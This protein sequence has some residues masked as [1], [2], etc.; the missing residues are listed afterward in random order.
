MVVQRKLIH[1]CQFCHVFD[2]NHIVRED[3]PKASRLLSQT[4]CIK[5]KAR[6]QKLRHDINA[7]CMTVPS[8]GRVRIADP[9]TESWRIKFSLKGDRFLEITPHGDR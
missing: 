3:R 1:V 2:Q 8:F 4:S 6:T 7:V 9:N 5:L